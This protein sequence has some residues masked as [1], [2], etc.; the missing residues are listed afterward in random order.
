MKLIS[1][2]FVAHCA[3]GSQIH[4]AAGFAPTAISPNIFTAAA[5]RCGTRLKLEVFAR[6]AIIAGAGHPACAVAVGRGT[7]IGMNRIKAKAFRNPERESEIRNHS[8]FW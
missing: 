7:M 5:A 3:N 1:H 2:A 8:D 4:R 6:A